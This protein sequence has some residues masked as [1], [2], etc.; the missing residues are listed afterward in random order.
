[1][2]LSTIGYEGAEQSEFI[3]ALKQNKVETLVDVREN[4]ISRKKGFSKNALR[5]A[6]VA[7]DIQYVHFP[8][9]GPR[10][11]IRKKYRSNKDWEWLSKE[12]LQYLY[13]NR[14]NIEELARLIF[15][16]HCCL[17]CFEADHTL[18]HRSLLVRY[19]QD[20]LDEKFDIDY[21]VVKKK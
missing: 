5:E 7:N 12:Y 21:I 4:P 10:S 15:Q 18:C 3:E 17:M 14:Q 19:L 16:S 8:S 2:V 6:L 11:E 13:A 1:M 9:L 20:T